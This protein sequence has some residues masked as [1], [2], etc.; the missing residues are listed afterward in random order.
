MYATPR[1][2]R[3]FPGMKWCLF[4][5]FG[6]TVRGKGN[7]NIASIG[8]SILGNP[9]VRHDTVLALLFYI[10]S[11]QLCY[12]FLLPLFGLKN[13]SIFS[14]VHDIFRP[15]KILTPKTSTHP[16]PLPRWGGGLKKK[17]KFWAVHDISWTFDFLTP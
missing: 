8:H 2:L 7:P 14:A 16:F 17:K 11:C 3:I 10:I 9:K 4:T 13:V 1:P 15:F 6:S 5:P 12:P